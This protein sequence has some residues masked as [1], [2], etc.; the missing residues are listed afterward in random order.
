VSCNLREALNQGGHLFNF[1]RIIVRYDS[2][3]EC[4]LC[5]LVPQK[6]QKDP[7]SLEELCNITP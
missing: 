6:S 5:V 3:F 7:V 1:S 4:N 2:F